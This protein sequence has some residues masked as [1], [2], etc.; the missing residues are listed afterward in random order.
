MVQHMAAEMAAFKRDKA[1][2]E[3]AAATTESHVHV[4]RDRA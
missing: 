4:E 2:A 1:N 3:T